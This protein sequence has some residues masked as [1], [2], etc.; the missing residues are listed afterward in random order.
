M[1]AFVVFSMLGF[2]PVT[3]G[4]AAYNIGSPV[5]EKA[6]VMLS[7]GS[8]LHIIAQ[9]ASAENKYIQRA[10]LNGH[11]WNQPWF[12]HDDIQ[13]GGTLVLVMG[14]YPNKQWGTDAVPPSEK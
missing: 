1:T 11:D 10:T 14:R 2:Y 3:P 8:T 6:E 12:S 13:Y 7:N 9:G 5:F 4:I